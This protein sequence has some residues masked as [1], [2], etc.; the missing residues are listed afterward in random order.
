[1]SVLGRTDFIPDRR[2]G[3]PFGFH[4][5]FAR[6]V[7]ANA[8]SVGVE[9]HPQLLCANCVRLRESNPPTFRCSDCHPRFV[10]IKGSTIGGSDNEPCDWHT[11][12]LIHQ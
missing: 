4:R 9:G 7:A 5:V 8:G 12:L 6:L 1:M 3:V 11:G 2:E 10:P